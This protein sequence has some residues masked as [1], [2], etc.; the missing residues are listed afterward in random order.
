MF[1]STFRLL[2]ALVLFATGSA[3][4]GPS[5]TAKAHFQA[6]AS[7]DVQ[8][9][10][11]AYADQAQFH[12]IGG[13]LDGTYGSTEAIRGVWTKFIAAQ[14]PLKLTVGAIEESTNP[15][16]ATVSANVQF[17]GKTP[18]NV[19]YVLVLRNDKI[20]GEVWQIDPKLVVAA[21]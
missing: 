15:M 8:T 17:Q 16:G 9:T 1:N 19:R 4:A 2:P 21:H 14:G 10:M 13:P 11:N 6:I 20:V 3:F 12:W 5:D 7:G 18:I